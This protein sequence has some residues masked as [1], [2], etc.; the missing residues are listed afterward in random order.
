[1]LEVSKNILKILGLAV[2]KAAELEL[3]RTNRRV[4]IL[5][6]DGAGLV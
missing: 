4:K 1:M 2:H 3:G 5:V 6:I